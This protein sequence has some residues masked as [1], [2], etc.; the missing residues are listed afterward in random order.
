[1]EPPHRVL[2][3]PAMLLYWN[4]LWK[5]QRYQRA[6]AVGRLM[7]EMR[8]SLARALRAKRKQ[9][10][11]TQRELAHLI[12]STQSTVSRMERPFRKVS[13]D[14]I[15]YAL[16]AM[17]ADDREVAEAFYAGSREDVRNLRKRA[18]APFYPKPS[19]LIDAR[20]PNVKDLDLPLHLWR[21]RFRVVQ[22]SDPHAEQQHRR[23]LVRD[24]EGNRHRM[25]QGQHT[26]Q[27][28]RT[29]DEE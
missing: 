18:S 8:Y 20:Q 24:A 23:R 25:Q 11:I 9:L 3:I 1:M 28:L 2:Q 16:C 19:T 17:G 4:H 21:E 13:L 29:D 27:V 12:N 26:E 22:R 7:F 10:K 15:V 14:Q 5:S 6:T